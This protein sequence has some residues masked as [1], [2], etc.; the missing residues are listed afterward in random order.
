MTFMLP[1]EPDVPGFG[2]HFEDGM[3][4]GNRLVLKVPKPA[5]LRRRKQHASYKTS[6]KP[7]QNAETPHCHKLPKVRHLKPTTPFSRYKVIIQAKVVDQ[8]V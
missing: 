8:P 6:H 3:A 5:G 1:P 7:H 2:V 4:A